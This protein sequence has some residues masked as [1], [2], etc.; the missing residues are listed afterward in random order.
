MTISNP[1]DVTLPPTADPLLN[2]RQVRKMF[3]DISQMT[4]W[5]WVRDGVL[6]EPKRINGR[7]YW[8]LSQV[9]ELQRK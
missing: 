9:Q 6:P 3:G 1:S 2:S 8:F 4:L 5:R 7:D